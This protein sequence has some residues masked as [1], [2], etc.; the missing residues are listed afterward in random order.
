MYAQRHRFLYH[1]EMG[2][3]QSDGGVYTQRYQ[4]P[5]VPLTKIVTLT[6]HVNEA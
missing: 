3:I 1:L 4:R 6:V 2:S 5:K